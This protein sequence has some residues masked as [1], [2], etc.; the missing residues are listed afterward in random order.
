MLPLGQGGGSASF[1]YVAAGEMPLVGEIVVGRGVDG[2]EFLQGLYVSETVSKFSNPKYYSNVL[3][4]GPIK[5]IPEA[6]LA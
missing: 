6:G 4:S 2:G 1:E 5:G 3:W